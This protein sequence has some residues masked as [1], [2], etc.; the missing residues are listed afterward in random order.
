MKPLVIALLVAGAASAGTYAFVSRSN[1]AALTRQ[2][3][4]LEA[5]WKA[6]K[7]D[8]LARRAVTA[9]PAETREVTKTVEVPVAVQ[10]SPEAILQKLVEVP[11][12]DRRRAMR[13]V[14]HYLESLVDAGP[15][16][17]P[18][19]AA[20]LKQNQ[21]V[22]YLARRDEGDAENAGRGREEQRGPGGPG[23]PGG[24]GG[25]A[26]RAL[27]GGGPGGPGGGRGNSRLEFASPPSLRLGLFDVLKTIGGAE[28]EAIL[29][30]TLQTTGRG[31]EVAYLAKTLEEMAPN[32]YRDIAI[33]AAHELLANP[34]AAD[35]G[36]RLDDNARTYLFELL[37][38]YGDTSFAGVAA[39]LL[40]TQEGGVDA[41]VL[42]YLRDTLQEQA[43]PAIYQAWKDVR[44]T[45]LADRAALMQAALPQA[46][47]NALANDMFRDALN[48][49]EVPPQVRAMMAQSLVNGGQFGGGRGGGDNA[50]TVDPTQ[51]RQKLAFLDTL[52]GQVTDERVLRSL[53]LAGQNLQSAAEGKPVQ[54]SREMMRELFRG[55]GGGG[56]GRGGNAGGPPAPG[57]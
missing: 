10:T 15:A 17:L 54:S 56:R 8:L 33:A 52:A 41:T 4:E 26:L 44:M 5:A 7:G 55:E 21:D 24:R 47:L 30:E 23:G 53:E 3:A 12:D 37:T 19:I 20:F 43:L 39:G 42:R 28:A 18:V 1:E 27:F 45:N 9:R 11:L 14:I 32:K 51:A 35:N 36:S 40:V 6:E 2:K 31:L 25:E 34:P 16:A 48:N 29:A 38:K 22:E 46:G 49:E 57:Q 50:A 13:R